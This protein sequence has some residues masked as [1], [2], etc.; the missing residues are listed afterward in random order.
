[1]NTTL[2]VI[3]GILALIFA[4]SGL[5]VLL[6]KEQLKSKLSWLTEYSSRMVLFICL[7]KVIGA[8]GIVLP[9]YFNVL[10]IITPL[11]AIGLASIM[12]L[13]LRYHIIK[14]EIK[15]IPATIILLILALFIVYNRF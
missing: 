1:M 2:L 4:S 5:I 10:L 15:D 3:Q 9:I 11:A 6:F 8:I 7:S 12:V 13:A 14:K